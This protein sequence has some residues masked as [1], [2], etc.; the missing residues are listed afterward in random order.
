MVS[1]LSPSEKRAAITKRLLIQSL[2]PVVG[3]PQENL[4]LSAGSLELPF[5]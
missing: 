4:S 5:Y 2:F 3:R 1:F